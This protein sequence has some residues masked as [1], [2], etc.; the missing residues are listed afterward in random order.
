MIIDELAPD[1]QKENRN[2]VTGWR[3]WTEKVYQTKLNNNQ[4]RKYYGQYEY[5]D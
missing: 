4:I 1:W 3:M 2:Y 5:K